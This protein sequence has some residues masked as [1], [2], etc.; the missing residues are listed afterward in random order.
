[1]YYRQNVRYHTQAQ[2]LL[3]FV[4]TRTDPMTNRKLLDMHILDQLVLQG[5]GQ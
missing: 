1:M 4:D 5:L 2:D 3:V